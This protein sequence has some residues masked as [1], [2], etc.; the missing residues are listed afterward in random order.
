MVLL[1]PPHAELRGP[2]PDRQVVERQ[3]RRGLLDAAEL[4][5]GEARVGGEPR[6][7]DGAAGAGL[8]ERHLEHGGGHE[9]RHLRAQRA[10]GQV[11]HEELPGRFGQRGAGVGRAR[12]QLGRLLRA[13][14]VGLHQ[15]LRLRLDLLVP[16]PAALL[17]L[18][19]LQRLHHAQAWVLLDQ[20]RDRRDGPLDGRLPQHV[21]HPSLQRL[22]LLLHHL[23]GPFPL[24]FLRPLLLPITAAAAARP[25]TPLP[26]PVA[27]PA[28]AAA[29]AAAASAA[30]PPVLPPAGAAA[31]AGAAVWCGGGTWSVVC[32]RARHWRHGGAGFD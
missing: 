28:A 11:P 12:P 7:D 29:P 19:L 30:P 22:R 17:L 24:P 2:A 5:E 32:E 31:A 4:D 9:G 20:L 23:V 14:Q 27:V 3:R 16:L 18:H 25:R 15:R 8:D 6:V 13:V 1:G 10:R 26:V 21:H